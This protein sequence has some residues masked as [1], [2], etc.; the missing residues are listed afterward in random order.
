M[1][2]KLET[3]PSLTDTSRIAA[4]WTIP[5]GEPTRKRWSD[6]LSLLAGLSDCEYRLSSLISKF[7]ECICKRISV[8][9]MV[10]MVRLGT[11]DTIY[12]YLF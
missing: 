8:L 7:L 2:V 4:E 11:D 9:F 5:V 1:D 12:E 3:D 6:Y 10:S